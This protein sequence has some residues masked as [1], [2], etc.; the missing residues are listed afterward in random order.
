VCFLS[1]SSGKQTVRELGT[2]IQKKEKKEKAI[3]QKE[4]IYIYINIRTYYNSV[5]FA[6]KSSFFFIS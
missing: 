4:Y 2:K 6:L 1:A 5:L 3:F